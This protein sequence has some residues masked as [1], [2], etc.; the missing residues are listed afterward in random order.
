[1]RIADSIKAGDLLAKTKRLSTNVT[2]S[3]VLET[4]GIPPRPATWELGPNRNDYFHMWQHS[5][6]C[7]G[8]DL[9]TAALLMVFFT[10]CLLI[11]SNTDDASVRQ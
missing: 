11:L 10:A 4:A 7:H 3:L 8:A 2:A 5:G 1:M 9:E 6:Y